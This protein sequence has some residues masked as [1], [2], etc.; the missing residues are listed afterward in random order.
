M[1]ATAAALFLLV[2]HTA[3]SHCEPPVTPSM[4][5]LLSTTQWQYIATGTANKVYRVTGTDFVVRAGL[6]VKTTRGWLLVEKAEFVKIL[7]ETVQRAQ[8]ALAL[9][10]MWANE[11]TWD[12]ISTFSTWDTEQKTLVGFHLGDAASKV[13]MPLAIERR[14][15]KLPSDA[16]DQL[17]RDG[18][19]KYAQDGDETSFPSEVIMNFEVH[20]F[21]EMTVAKLLQNCKSNPSDECDQRM[22]I[23]FITV[24]ETARDVAIEKKLMH[25]DLHWHNVFLTG[26]R[27][28]F[29][30]FG[31]SWNTS[32]SDA[33]VWRIHFERFEERVS[34]YLAAWKNPKLRAAFEELVEVIEPMVNDTLNTIKFFELIV[35]ETKKLVMPVVAADVRL[36]E[37]VFSSFSTLL[38]SSL[39]NLHNATLTLKAETNRLQAANEGQ[40]LELQTVKA[41]NKDQYMKIQTQDTKIQRLETENKQLQDQFNALKALVEKTLPQQNASDTH[42]EL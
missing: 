38:G 9:R 42:K 18:I 15:F 10:V 31:T 30:D 16:Q 13:D 20:P 21:Y 36:Q 26:N 27:V 39:S 41:E 3:S 23:I 7:N 8:D 19:V 2:C 29:G 34:Q 32:V 25:N 33:S 35:D 11:N 17:M 24:H 6:G 14:C 37:R 4:S 40:D 28:V 1:T 22:L 12:H 5:A